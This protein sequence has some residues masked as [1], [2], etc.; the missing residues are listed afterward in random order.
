MDPLEQLRKQT[1]P[2]HK[3][4]LTT[5]ASLA[6]NSSFP[7]LGCTLCLD[8]QDKKLKHLYISMM[9]LLEI[10]KTYKEINCADV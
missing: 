9:R 10:Q 3:D 2:K 7:T 6:P 8:K 1:C 5:I 4:Q